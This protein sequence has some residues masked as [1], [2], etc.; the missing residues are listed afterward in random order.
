MRLTTDRTYDAAGFV[1]S[2]LLTTDLAGPTTPRLLS[3]AVSDPVRPTELADRAHA[4]AAVNGDFFALNTT[5]APIGPM[6]QG[7]A[8]LKADATPQTVVGLDAAGAGQI[9]DLLLE[10]EATV[11]G[12]SR[13]LAGLNGNTLPADSVGL[14][15]PAWGHG[16]RRFVTTTGGGAIEIEVRRGKVTAV[17]QGAG[18]TPVPADGLVLLATGAPAKD[19]AG[20][21]LGTQVSADYHARSNAPGPYSLALGAHLVLLRGGLRQPI[22]VGD[23][24]NAALKPRTAIGWTA[25]RHLLLYVAD[26]SSSRS[27]GLTASEL[28][29]RMA[30]LGATDAVM[31]D[32]GGSSQL[33]ARRPGDAVVTVTSAPSDGAQR[34]VPD[35]V[36]LVPPAGSGTLRGLDVRTSV[37]RVFPGLSRSVAVAGYDETYAPAPSGR[38]RFSTVPGDLARPDAT[39]ILRGAHPGSGE[40]V[41]RSGRIQARVPLRVLGPLDR[42]ESDAPAL[43]FASGDYRDVTITGRDA[44]GFSAPIEP[45]D[46]RMDYDHAVASVEA[47]PDGTLRVTG[48]PDADGTGTLLSVSVAGHQLVIPLTVGLDSVPIDSLAD[49]GRWTALAVKA[50]A[51]V[52]S[53]DTSDRPG[54]APG[55]RGLRLSYDFRNQPNGNSAAYAVAAA[56]LTLAPGTQR[57]ALWVKGDGH[58]HWLRAMM[59]AQGGTNVP[60]TF[61]Q[62]VDWTGW[63]R[64]E[65]LVPT[66]FT[67]PLALRRLYLV[68]TDPTRRDAGELDLALLDARV[69]VPLD[70]P[71]A[72]DQADPAVAE[73]GGRT[74]SRHAWRFAVISDTHV[75]ADGGT[76]SYAYTQTA[77]ALDQI[78]AARPDFV[79]LSGDGVDN[80]RP[81]DF[82]LFGRLLADHL[83]ASIPL[84]WAVGNHESGAVAG[85]TLDQFVASTGRPTRQVFDH[86]G[87]RFV[88]LNSTLGSLRLSDFA[89][90]GWLKQ[91]LAAAADDDAIT[92]VVVALHHPVL[93][94]TGTGASQLSDPNEAA[95][96]EQWLAAFRSASGKQIALVSG[97]AHTAHVRRADG[98]VELNAP[99]VGKVPYGDAG[100]GGFAAWSMVTLDPDDARVD[101]DRPD[102]GGPGWFQADVQ[103]LLS[104]VELTAPDALAVGARGTVGAVGIDDGQRGRI[105]PLRY[106]ASVTWSGSGLAVVFDADRLA[107]A[108]RDRR[109]VAVLDLR[110]GTLTGLRSGVA[111]VHV[112]SGSLDADRQVRVTS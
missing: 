40:L 25:D 27:R 30:D 56:P 24:T 94:P 89:Q 6:I 110:T 88:L 62:Q 37:A 103:P 11:D 92:S 47:R 87:T 111:E 53:V 21:P 19:L 98:V 13:P 60:F 33:V 63:R 44:E 29:D 106:P 38:V 108:R 18:A 107:A 59:S 69:G 31:L 39:G 42:L 71:D 34:A 52:G 78:A 50:Q 102:A 97:H 32:G 36:G 65:G 3:S 49:A 22:D 112:R 26:G 2:L 99:V 10:G 5:N 58:Q 12:R 93:D 67:A 74:P 81:E 28:A 85:G 109:N 17:R 54:A 66:G 61:A 76:G 80:D 20:T 101:P 35:A 1:D 72:G 48:R 45:R 91:Q 77:R 8:L 46:L 43:S 104:R 82:A 90:L 84:R 83:P 96:L 9:A 70:V 16:D 55:E 95:L 14:Y 68:E 105:V 86:A 15:T 100:H 4:V 73:Q 41:A 79:L 64:I 7:G 75:N 51:T 23:A 57:L